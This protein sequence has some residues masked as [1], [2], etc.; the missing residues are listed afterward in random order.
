MQSRVF[1]K[2]DLDMFVR[3]S[4]DYN[5]LHTN[6]V[7]ARRLIFGKQ[8]VHGVHLL[9][10]GLNCLLENISECIVLR[11]LHAKFFKPAGLKE[12]FARL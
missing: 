12:G 2:S 10:W 6:P 11:K 8:I 4:G 1:T 5:P 3:H 9:F 7:M